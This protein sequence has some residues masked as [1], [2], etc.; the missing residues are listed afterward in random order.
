VLFWCKL[1][2]RCCAKW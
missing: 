2:C 1:R